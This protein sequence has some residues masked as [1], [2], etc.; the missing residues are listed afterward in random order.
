M[1]LS[2]PKDILEYEKE[3]LSKQYAT[4]P[5][6]VADALEGESLEFSPGPES[7]ILDL[8][9]ELL[10]S[11][12][13]VDKLERAMKRMENGQSPAFSIVPS[14]LA[15]SPSRG[16]KTRVFHLTLFVGSSS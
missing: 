6:K 9:R 13:S 11:D 2:S 10:N 8:D 1:L 3:Y 15:G 16:D 5:D 4:R 7:L 14:V 12:L